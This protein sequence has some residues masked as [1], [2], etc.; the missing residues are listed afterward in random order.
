MSRG[1]LI[2]K[3]IAGFHL[4]DATATSYDED[5]TEPIGNRVDASVVEVLCQVE[6]PGWYMS[7]F[8][9]RG[10]K[11]EGTV[12]IILHFEDIE[13]LGLL[14]PTGRP[15]INS[16]TKLSY[17]KRENGLMVEEYPEGLYVLDVQTSSW[18]LSVDNDPTRNLLFLLLGARLND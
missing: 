6:E 14:S 13:S 17:I 11:G 7:T 8:T 16:G 12:S 2:N 18:G 4:L 5:Y 9:P 1:R 3:M 15:T 10:L